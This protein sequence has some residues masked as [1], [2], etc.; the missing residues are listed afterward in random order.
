[1]I[2]L[3]RRAR[4]QSGSGLTQARRVAVGQGRIAVSKQMRV[5]STGELAKHCLDA[6]CRGCESEDAKGLT[7][8]VTTLIAI[9]RLQCGQLPDAIRVPEQ[10]VVR[11]YAGTCDRPTGRAIPLV[12]MSSTSA[13][14]DRRTW[15]GL[16]ITRRVP[17]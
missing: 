15:G 10:R 16:S 11:E 5:R 4:R 17:G 3:G 12:P 7:E 6:S 9:S 2:K 8:I 1:M 13:A 14:E